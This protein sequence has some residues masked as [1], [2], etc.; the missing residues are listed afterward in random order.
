[1]ANRY[2]KRNT[3]PL[4]RFLKKALFVISLLLLASGVIFGFWLLSEIGPRDVDYAELELQ[5]EQ[6]DKSQHYRERLQSSIKFE[7]AFDEILVLREPNEEDLLL[8]GRA[9]GA[10]RD[11]VETAPNPDAEQIK[12]LEKLDKRYQNFAVREQQEKTQE[13]ERQAARLVGSGKPED[14][15]N[16]YL[17][18]L[19]MQ[20]KINEDFP[21]SDA[22]DP[23]RV[24]RLRRS[25][26]FLAA[27]PLYRESIEYE[28]V[29]DAQ[30]LIKDWAA[31]KEAIDKALELQDILNREHRGTQQADVGRYSQ[32]KKKLV[33][34]LSSKDFNQIEEISDL[35]D[36]RKV[37][38]DNLAA[39][40]Y[41]DEAARLQKLLNLKY[42]D[43]PYTSPER[44]SNFQRK[45]Q[46]AQSFKLGLE[47]EANH[48]ALEK[49]LSSQKIREAIEK[50]VDLRRDITQMQETYPRSSLNDA[51]LQIK[52]RYLN[53]LQN[54]LDFIQ[55]HLFR[56]VRPLPDSNGWSMLTTEVTQGL[57][58]IVMGT[59]PSR[60]KADDHPVDSVSWREAKTFCDRIS[61][62]MGKPVRLPS[63]NEFRSALG[64]L[65][66]L[67]LEEYTWSELDS[68]NKAQAV[69]SK[70]ALG[71]GY[72]DLLGNVSEWLESM[73]QYDDE[74]AKH[75]GGH[76][77][78]SLEAIFTVPVR[79]SPRGERNRMTGFR[80]VM[81]LN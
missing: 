71:E 3:S 53:L 66:Y 12:R 16:L 41:Y 6:D 28:R 17:E 23:A 80:I 30:L 37:V 29:S 54:D 46:T 52:I 45:S 35:A 7:E 73:D 9:L 56:R 38:G 63:E 72:F 39:A 25:A 79:S 18:A 26:E 5:L 70:K 32:L 64:R 49:L 60:I 33:G 1:M 22:Y 44:V 19:E 74:D 50:I 42:P 68:G 77:Q 11:F 78:D 40:S 58:S 14:A 76:A 15:Y 27:E 61:W 67:V 55:K 81:R 34:V 69:A 57:Y 4:W 65:R 24:A 13:L 43:S 21:K 8:L 10:Q 20:V 59:N 51:N 31:A 36:A 62:I 47:I 48:E 75:I 2:R